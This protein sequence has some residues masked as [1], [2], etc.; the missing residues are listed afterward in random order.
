[1]NLGNQQLQIKFEKAIKMLCDH[2]PISGEREKPQLMHSLRVGMYLFNN[3]YA[4]DVVIG[5]LLHDVIEWTD[6]PEK[7]IQEEFGQKVLKII[8]ANTKNREIKDVVERRKEYVDRC[9]E[10]GDEALIVKAADAIDSYKYYQ[11]IQRQ[12][13]IDRSIA[14]AKLIIKK[15]LK[16]KIVGEL[17]EV[18]KR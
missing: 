14:I 8:K 13:E 3:D 5:G 10:V 15:G 17:K 2:I 4:D 16:D 1:M 11:A 18:T 12:K 9:A 7:T 6:C